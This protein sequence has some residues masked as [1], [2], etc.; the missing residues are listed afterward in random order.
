[1]SATA[2]TSWARAIR[3]TVEQAGVDAGPLFVE[4]GLD[5]QALGDPNARYPVAR[6][7]RL[8]RLAVAATGN[9]ALGLEVARNVTPTTFHALG[10]SQ[11]ASTTLK[12]A[13]ERSVRYFHIISDAGELAFQR[14]GDEYRFEI[15]TEPGAD[16]PAQESMDAFAA[17]LVRMVRGLAGRDAWPLA[18]ELPRAAPANPALYRRVFGCAPRYGAA[19]TALVFD[20]ALI[21]RP[22]DGANPELARQNDQIVIEHLAR[23]SRSQLASRV[24]AMLVS[25]LPNGVPQ[26][27][28]IAAALHLSPRSLQRKLAAENTSFKALLEQSREALARA[29]LAAGSHSVS[30][31]T[32]LLGYTDTSAFSRAF[33]RWT[34]VAPSLYAS[35]RAPK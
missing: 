18:V 23:L 13:F 12:E 31:V 35:G 16:A 19:Q 27:G 4:A 26:A 10:Y 34:G 6:T 33:R 14:Q 11:V 8:W 5:L 9:P 3:R 17:V 30:E 1:M 28:K 15:R 29:Y 20:R 2:L 22:L 32:F 25:A 7:A 21:E 24:R